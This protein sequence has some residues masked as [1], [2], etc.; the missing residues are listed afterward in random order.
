M[1]SL[2][3]PHGWGQG[4]S[5][6]CWGS[7]VGETLVQQWQLKQYHGSQLTCLAPVWWW[8]VQVS[9][10]LSRRVC[11]GVCISHSTANSK[12]DSAAVGCPT[13]NMFLLDQKHQAGRAHGD[14]GLW[15]ACAMIMWVCMSF[16]SKPWDRPA[17][18]SRT[19]GVGKHVWSSG[20]HIKW[21]EGSCCAQGICGCVFAS[22]PG[23]CCVCAHTG[24]LLSLPALGR[25][26]CESCV[27]A[28]SLC[29]Q[30]RP[31]PLSV[32]PVWDKGSA[33]LGGE[34]EKEKGQPYLTAW[35]E[36]PG[37]WG[38]KLGPRGLAGKSL[39]TDLQEM[40]AATNSS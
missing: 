16:C 26:A 29:S 24:H 28:A 6:A 23:C 12:L 31:C 3:V 4:L 34:L 35:A 15:C 22:E 14:E 11:M 19:Q 17:G 13:S 25:R 7:G 38:T 21:T 18:K 8:G 1:I 39:G 10:S 9:V 30:P 36:T 32:L 37:L 2:S 40:G 5:A 20:R 33:S 27:C